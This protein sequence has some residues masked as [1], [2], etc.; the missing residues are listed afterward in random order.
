VVLTARHSQ[1][2]QPDNNNN[3]GEQSGS[4]LEDAT[5]DAMLADAEERP[6]E[7]RHIKGSAAS[8][9]VVVTQ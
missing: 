6:E 2:R 5:S 9:N 1:E 7:Q 4:P 8:A 3:N